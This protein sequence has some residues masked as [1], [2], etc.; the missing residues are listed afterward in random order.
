M[1]PIVPKDDYDIEPEETPEVSI[2][3]FWQSW[4]DWQG[5]I[6]WA[7]DYE[8]FS[9][10]PDWEWSLTTITFLAI[11]GLSFGLAL[12][13]FCAF[14]NINDILN[15]VTC[16]CWTYIRMIFKCCTCWFM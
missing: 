5:W 9:W 2:D 6:N 11:F 4:L 13:L 12:C 7:R 3:K 10:F 15:A 16:G 14:K 8:W 1:A